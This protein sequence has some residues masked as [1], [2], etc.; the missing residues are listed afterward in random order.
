MNKI[1]TIVQHPLGETPSGYHFFSH[2]DDHYFAVTYF[3]PKYD[4]PVWIVNEFAFDGNRGIVV[5]RYTN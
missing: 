1:P 4:G 2:L 5:A 3:G